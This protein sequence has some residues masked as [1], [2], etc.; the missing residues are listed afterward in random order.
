MITAE[1]P[2]IITDKSD[3]TYIDNY[4]NA[5][6]ITD[7]TPDTI[8]SIEYNTVIIAEG[9]Q[10]PTGPTGP[11]GTEED[12]MYAKRVDFIEEEDLLYRGEAVPGTLDANPVWRIRKITIS[13]ID[14]DVE[15]TWAGGND[16]FDKIWD[17]RLS[18][19]YS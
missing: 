1:A 13:A 7:T 6:Y 4:T 3:N 17:N 5:T 14:S 9:I 11:S 19:T 15:E 2:T 12:A 8:T 18:Y 16:T 10:G